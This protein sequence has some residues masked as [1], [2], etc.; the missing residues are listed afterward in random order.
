[1]GDGSVIGWGVGQRKARGGLKRPG[2]V[3]V[4][5]RLALGSGLAVCVAGG[6]VGCRSAEDYREEA[7][8]RA[9][10]IVSRAQRAA[11][12]RQE[13]FTIDRPADTLRERLLIQ[14]GLPIASAASLGA[15]AV[16][17][18]KH[19]PDEAYL[20]ENEAVESPASVVGRDGVAGGVRLSLLEAL[21]IAAQNSRDYQSR[22]ETVFVS[23][24]DLDL[25]RDRFRPTFGGG[26]DAEVVSDLTGDPDR[27][28]GRISPELSFSQRLENGVSFTGAIGLDLVQLFTQSENSSLGLYGDASVS[29][30]LLRG[31]GRHI[32]REP[33]TQAERSTIYAIYDF[34]R[35][36]REFV[37][38][39]ASRYLGVLQALD[40]VTNA[41]QNYRSLIA[42][43]R[44]LRA[45]ADEGR[46]SEVEVDQAVQNEL[47]ARDRW[48]S[49]QQSYDRQL[50]SF[51]IDLGL[52]ADALVELERDE[53][54]RLGAA[55]REALA[56]TETPSD[57][58]AEVS[59]PVES[60]E[61]AQDPGRGARM[62]GSGADAEIVL[63]PP[64]REDAG[65]YE[66]EEPLAVALA[67]SNR[68]DLRR[69]EGEVVDSQRRV[70]IA[71]DQLR[72]ELTL[73]G[74]ASLGERRGA[75]SGDADDA[76]S[77]RLDEG[78]YSGLLTLDLPFERT[79]ERN[80]YRV[81]LIN[82]ERS[83]RDLQALEDQIK[84]DVRDRLRVL[85]TSREGLKIQAA[86]VR[87]AE[88]R[89]ESTRLFLETGRAQTRDLLEAQEDLISAQ[90][91]LTS[92]LVSYRVAELELQRDMG[93]LQVDEN[94]L[95][96]ELDPA[97]I[98]ALR[99]GQRPGLQPTL[100]GAEG[101]EDAAEEL[102]GAE[103]IGVNEEVK[104]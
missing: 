46:V 54:Q 41:E 87:L 51:R 55:V 21:A 70:V 66:L 12:G 17:P 86:A 5:L 24:L 16:D 7:N 97:M 35:F 81:S 93:V 42:S 13:T 80:A 31:S 11:L 71:A 33:L 28:G 67:L 2:D 83:V 50:D 90:N 19:W 38:R 27:A 59:E 91:A 96:T 78:R 10:D 72:A 76:N 3:S 102:R 74:S 4:G 34:E 89:V 82:F 65:P 37:V 58:D 36:K 18:V 45:L 94:A 61:A 60:Q 22:K 103:P 15:T 100:P 63:D 64:T 25:Q 49:A 52:P 99:A 85:L 1:M 8:K 84:A 40:Q 39:I 23:A 9:T 101:V 30:P 26:G 62:L 92:A 53:I 73:L 43:A 14:Q 88:R 75:L 77:L 56:M 69:T 47:Q 48:I 68:L 20:E 57:G 6:L 98:E 95:W 79:A 104:G 32:V 29:V 44:R